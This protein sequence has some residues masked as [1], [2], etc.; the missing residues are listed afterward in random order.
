MFITGIIL[1]YQ[2]LL[3]IRYVYILLYIN[4]IFLLPKNTMWQNNS[5]QLYAAY[6]PA[7]NLPAG[8]KSVKQI[9][10]T[11][12]GGHNWH[13]CCQFGFTGRVL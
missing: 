9:T 3:F 11:A 10:T 12:P 8:R 1:Y 4:S 13:T 7:K 2:W 5:K 6:P